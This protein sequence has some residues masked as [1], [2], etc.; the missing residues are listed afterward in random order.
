MSALLSHFDRS[1]HAAGL[2]IPGGSAERMGNSAEAR[3]L[4][5]RHMEVLDITD[6][7][8]RG[9]AYG[10]GQIRLDAAAFKGDAR[11]ARMQAMDMALQLVWGRDVRATGIVPM[12]TGRNDGNGRLD[13]FMPQ[14]SQALTDIL[15]SVYNYRFANLPYWDGEYLPIDGR[16]ADP[17]ANEIV[18]YEQKLLGMPRAASTYDVSSIPLVPGSAAASNIVKIVPALVGMNVNFMDPRRERAAVRNSKPDFQIE[19]GKVNACRR[20]IAEFYNALWAYGDGDTGMDGLHNHPQIAT[21]DI[22]TPWASATPLQM[23]DDLSTMLNFIIDNS[24][25]DL[26]DVSKIKIH[27]PPTQFNKASN[28]PLT[29]AG[30]DMVLTKFLENWK[31]KPD[32]VVKKWDLAAVN[33]AAYA[34][35]PQSFTRDRAIITYLGDG[36]DTGLD[37]DPSFTLTQPTETPFPDRND[38]LSLTTYFHARGGTLILPDARRV[39]RVVGL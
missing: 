20:V 14:A 2:K 25:G 12:S 32:Q 38:G 10:A 35:G 1:A 19:I 21:L 22:L 13:S 28:T 34:G 27:L 11:K 26:G 4:L 33:S 8:L 16:G 24:L 37:G 6:A 39:L 9:R 3:S 18:W 29:S 15:K 7:L 30:T 23:N 5:A 17:A 31:L 36:K